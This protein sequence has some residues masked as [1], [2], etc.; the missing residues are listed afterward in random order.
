MATIL[1]FRSVPRPAAASA[2]AAAG[3]GVSADIVFFPGVRYE[4]H[5]E[6][7]AKPKKGKPRRDTL[8]LE[9]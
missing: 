6:G 3:A 4:R 7:D 2:L 1:E 5:D 8:E 9:S